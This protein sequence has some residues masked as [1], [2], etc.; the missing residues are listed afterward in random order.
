MV[1]DKIQC[2]TK[3]NYENGNFLTEEKLDNIGAHMDACPKKSVH[4]FSLELYEHSF[5][6]IGRKQQ[7]QQMVQSD[8]S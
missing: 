2:F 3:I 5:L 8:D 1:S 4:R 6:C 7:V